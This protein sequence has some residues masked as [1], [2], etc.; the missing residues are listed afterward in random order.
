[1]NIHPPINAL[2]SALE[3][4]LKALEQAKN[5]NVIWY[6]LY[7]GK[8]I[9]RVNIRLHGVTVSWKQWNDKY[10]EMTIGDLNNITDRP[11]GVKYKIRFACFLGGKI[12][13]RAL[14]FEIANKNPKL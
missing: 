11:N 9:K 6:M 4:P 1:M 8:I 12:V 10:N 2:V 14:K 7:M 5:K 13:F 3:R